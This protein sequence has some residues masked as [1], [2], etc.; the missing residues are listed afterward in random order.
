MCT[1]HTLSFNCIGVVFKIEEEY[2][3]I[4]ISLGVKIKTKTNLTTRDLTMRDGPV[5]KSQLILDVKLRK[6]HRPTLL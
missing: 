5:F 3:L 1:K 4:Y 6:H 2:V